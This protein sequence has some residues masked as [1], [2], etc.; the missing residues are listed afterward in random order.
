MTN[1][2]WL[3]FPSFL[4]INILEDLDQISNLLEELGKVSFPLCLWLIL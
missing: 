2:K 1:L 4:W 3:S